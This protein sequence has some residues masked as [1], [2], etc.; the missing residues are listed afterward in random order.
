MITE[1]NILAIT[2]KWIVACL[3]NVQNI[4]LVTVKRYES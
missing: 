3:R 1:V 2:P 4:G